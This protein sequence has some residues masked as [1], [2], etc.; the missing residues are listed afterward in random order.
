ARKRKEVT[1]TLL[2]GGGATCAEAEVALRELLD[3]SWPAD[4]SR[5]PPGERAAA[6]SGRARSAGGDE[7]LRD[8]PRNAA[9]RVE[10][11]PV[12]GCGFGQEDRRREGRP[13]IGR[14]DQTQCGLRTEKV[15]GV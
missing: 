4:G 15:G 2:T 1:V 11:P 13:S 8:R 12:R 7:Q 14:V 5:T 3:A 10:Q 9:G 6:S